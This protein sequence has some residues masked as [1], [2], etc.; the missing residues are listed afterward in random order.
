MISKSHFI[1]VMNQLEELRIK[2]DNLDIALHDLC[3]S[4]FGSLYS[5]LPRY[6]N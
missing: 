5:G 3:G 2:Q 6:Y 4:G 1:D